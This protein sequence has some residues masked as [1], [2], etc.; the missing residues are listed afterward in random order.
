M[1]SQILGAPDDGDSLTQRKYMKWE[2]KACEVEF[3]TKEELKAHLRSYMIPDHI[4]E[5]SEKKIRDNVESWEKFKGLW[6]LHKNETFK[7]T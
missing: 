3:D 1:P 2:C 4:V 5:D 7:S 6:I